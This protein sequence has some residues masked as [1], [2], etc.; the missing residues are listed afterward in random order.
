MSLWHHCAISVV[1]FLYLFTPARP[2]CRQ[3]RQRSGGFPRVDST[4]FDRP[5]GLTLYNTASCD[6]FLPSNCSAS[7]QEELFPSQTLVQDLHFDQAVVLCFLKS[8]SVVQVKLDQECNKYSVILKLELVCVLFCH[9]MVWL[10]KGFCS[11]ETRN[12]TCAGRWL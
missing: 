8:S 9:H 10:S 7:P 2:Q 12:G 6:H 5:L 4:A 1:L 11:G 3:W